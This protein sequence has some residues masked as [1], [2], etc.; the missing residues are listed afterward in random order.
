MKASRLWFAVFALF[1]LQT[2]FI[3]TSCGNGNGNG[4]ETSDRQQS[5]SQVDIDLDQIIENGVIRAITSYSPVSYFIYRGQPMGYEY[6]LLNIF[7]ERHNL[8]VEVLVARDLDEMIDM[9]NRG[10]GDL[11]AY[12]MTVTRDRRE[13]LEFTTPFNTTRQVLVQRK[14][15]GWRQMRLH[16]IERSLLRSPIELAGES[17]VVRRAS[18]YL[19]RMENLQNEIGADIDVLEAESGFTTEQLIRMVAERE[20]DYTI[21]DENIARLNQAYFPILDIETPVSLPQQ[22]AW[23]VRQNSPQMLDAINEWL[24]EYQRDSEYYVIYNKYFENTRAYRSR[25]S[26]QLLFSEGGQ[27]SSYD[28]IILEYAQEIDW[29]WKLLAALIYQES[30][31]NPNASSWAGAVGLMQLM[32]R[33]A[34][35]YG[36]NDPTDPR[37]SIEAGVKFI[38]WLQDYWEDEIE[39]P[40]E[41]QKF[42][43]ASYNVGQGHVQDARRLADAF[44]ADPNVWDDNVAVYLEKKS[45]EDYY[46]H[47]AV[48]YGYARGVE[49]VRYVNSIYYIYQHYRAIANL[50][51]PSPD[52]DP[53]VLD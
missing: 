46:N 26:S 16:E 14:P 15:D 9:L 17:V 50:Q 45:Y 36:A 1:L 48:R 38:K 18:S 22:T 41:R 44:G 29:D 8:E 24:A 31:F 25:L 53:I 10:E 23:A 28:D 20:I 27:I 30:Q 35:A 7:A 2:G 37:E 4:N 49:P 47:E 3:L 33:T 32:P 34:V 51:I 13:V 43:I 11:I 19:D 39:D 5:A 21:S 12:G 52:E 6:E 42:I 40:A